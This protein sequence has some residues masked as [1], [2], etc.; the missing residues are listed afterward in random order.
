MAFGSQWM[1]PLLG[2]MAAV[3]SAAAGCGA[4]AQ[5]APD[6]LRIPILYITKE[7]PARLPLSLVEPIVPDQGL[8]G[9]QAGIQDN[10]TTGRFLN[11]AYEL[12]ARIV[13]E[14][15]D[16]LAA[17]EAELAG[18]HRL[19]VADVRGDQLLA[20]ADAPGAGEA[21]IFNVRA[22]DDALRN[23]ACRA[24]VLHVVPSR[25]MLADAL[26]QYLVWKKWTRWFLLSGI[27]AG[28]RAY[29]EALRRA[30][31]KFGA[32]IVEEREIEENAPSARTDTGHVQI[33][34]QIPVLT[35]GAPGH[36]VV[37]VADERDVFGEYL[38]YRTWDPRPV[39]GTQGLIATP[40][41][42]SQEQ[43]GATQLQRRFARFAGRDMTERD[44]TAWAAVRAIGEAVTRTGAADVEAIKDYLLGDEFKLAAFKGEALTFRT[45]N[46]QLRQ[47]VLL[48]A[49]RTLV[50][51]SPQQ[52]FL[53]R[54]S[55]LDTLGFDRP[56]SR[57]RVDMQ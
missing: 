25:A 56:E 15:G 48:A 50:S 8:V 22:R 42:R 44:Y 39:V 24:N 52:G 27:G 28:D 23:E 17:F 40:W 36:D 43:W 33:Q 49:P 3:L 34:R 4:A 55:Q 30:A 31:R 11:H 5:S 20:L 2:V 38:P 12:S 6:P 26:A 41:H 45:W 18:G 16:L 21:L 10:N 57:C 46:G 9:A 13:P 47:P 7:E 37:M 32:K 51:V 19:V 14:A 1:S 54:H 53:H 35:Q 29:A